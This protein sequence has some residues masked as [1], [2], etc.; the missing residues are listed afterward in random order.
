MIRPRTIVLPDGG[1]FRLRAVRPSDAAAVIAHVNAIAAER[2]YLMTERLTLSIRQ[3]Q[4]ILRQFRG[5]AGCYL[6]AE[7]DGEIV[8]TATFARAKPEKSRHVGSLGIALRRDVRG[9]GLGRAMME[10]GIEWARSAGIRKL[11]LG[12]F[13][14]NRRA[15][16]LYRRLGFVPEGRLRGQVLLRGRPDDELLMALWLDRPAPPR[17]RAHRPQA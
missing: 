2:I 10:V 17:T 16:R 4:R 7:Q 15:I 3:E 6:V 13:A 9:R 12:V 5:R 1:S 11:T 8:G 14:S